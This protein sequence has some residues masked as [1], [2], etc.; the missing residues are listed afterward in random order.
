[1]TQAP[2]AGLSRPAP[3]SRWGWAVAGLWLGSMHWDSNRRGAAMR[4]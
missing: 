4:V 1:M 3:Q 2:S